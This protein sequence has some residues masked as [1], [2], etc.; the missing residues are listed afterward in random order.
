M[1]YGQENDERFTAAIL[2]CWGRCASQSRVW[3]EIL[4]SN[5]WQLR[6]G[7]WVFFCNDVVPALLNFSGWD[8]NLVSYVLIN[9][10]VCASEKSC[11]GTWSWG[12]KKCLHKC[13]RRSRD[14]DLAAWVYMQLR[15]VGV[16]KFE[17]GSWIRK[18]KGL[19]G[20]RSWCGCAFRSRSCCSKRRLDNHT[21]CFR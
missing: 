5:L 9:M 10:W 16:W 4:E 15:L 2:Q 17:R 21:G 8:K 11:L 18:D 12:I 7:S 19:K 14:M 20:E 6:Q 1:W 3:R 13:R